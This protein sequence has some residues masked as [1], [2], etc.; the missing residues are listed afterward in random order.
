MKKWEYLVQ[1]CSRLIAVS[2]ALDKHGREGWEL[3]SVFQ[4]NS[5]LYVITMKRE[6][7]NGT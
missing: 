5:L 3:V 2:D 4:D 1:P 7:K 6:K